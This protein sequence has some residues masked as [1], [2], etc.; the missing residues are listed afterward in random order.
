MIDAMPEPA[1]PHA[2]VGRRSVLALAV[3]GAAGTLTTAACGIRLDSDVPSLPFLPRTPIPGEKALVAVTAQCATLAQQ[4][5]AAGSTPQLVAV[6]ALHTR[7]H[8]VLVTAL[9]AKG[10]P[11][12]VIAPPTPASTGSP[13][14]ATPDPGPTDPP[15]TSPSPT[16]QLLGELA[17]AEAG[18]LAEAA[19]FAGADADLRATVCALLAQRY[20]TATLLGGTPPGPPGTADGAAT[21]GTNPG[22]PVPGEAVPLLAATRS[23]AYGFDIVAAQG[24]PRDRALARTTLATL[25][26]L[27]GEQTRSLGPAAPQPPLGYQLPFAVSTPAA[28]RRLAIHLVQGLRNA[29]GTALDPLI[30][31]AGDQTFAH[32]PWWLGRAEV[33]AERWG[34]PPAPFPG[35][36]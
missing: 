20:A 25:A 18:A 10:V 7:Q 21:G 15:G 16:A 26:D 24:A 4:A 17:T 6:A 29:Y 22:W 34:Q 13:S 36:T 1:G 8:D 30:R 12:D 23:A 2:S 9:R 28:A 19:V 3:L 32:V 5:R 27:V 14:G 31:S 11:E 33:L 35:L